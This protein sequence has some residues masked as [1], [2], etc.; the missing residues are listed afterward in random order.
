MVTVDS[1]LDVNKVTALG[2]LEVTMEW[3]VELAVDTGGVADD[4]GA[5]LREEGDDDRSAAD[6]RVLGALRSHTRGA[7]GGYR[8]SDGRVSGR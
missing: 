6:R 4:G 1:G 3:K 8:S 2:V 7:K 5:M